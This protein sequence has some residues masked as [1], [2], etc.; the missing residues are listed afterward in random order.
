MPAYQSMLQPLS[1][2]FGSRWSRRKAGPHTWAPM[3]P[4]VGVVSV[5]DQVGAVEQVEWTTF[6]MTTVVMIS[7]RPVTAP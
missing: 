2:K 4:P 5:E 6:I 7:D 3:S 1:W